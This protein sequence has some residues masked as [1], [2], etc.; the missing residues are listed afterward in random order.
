MKYINSR[1]LLFESMWLILEV[2]Y[3][4]FSCFKCNLDHICAIIAI[5]SLCH[6]LTLHYSFS[7]FSVSNATW[8]IYALLLLFYL[9]ATILQIKYLHYSFSFFSVSNATWIIYALLLLFIFMIQSYRSNIST[10]LFPMLCTSSSCL[11]SCSG[12]HIYH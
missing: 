10:I 3:F 1:T 7:F 6:N 12:L 2:L 5:L 9:Y 11:T 4:P 8:I